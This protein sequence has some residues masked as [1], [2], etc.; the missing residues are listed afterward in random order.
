[1]YFHAFLHSKKNHHFL[2]FCFFSIFALSFSMGGSCKIDSA[3]QK[4]KNKQTGY[5]LAAKVN[6]TEQ[7]KQSNL[8][9]SSI[10]VESQAIPSTLTASDNNLS[11][12]FSYGFQKASKYGR[13]MNVLAYVTNNGK[14]FSGT[15]GIL[16]IP[17]SNSKE[18]LYENPCTIASGETKK[19]ELTATVAYSNWPSLLIKD[20]QE[21]IMLQKSFHVTMTTQTDIVFT[22]ILT[23]EPEMMDYI[24]SA[25]LAKVFFLDEQTLPSTIDGLDSLDILMISNFNTNRLSSDQITAILEW[26]KQGGMLVFGTGSTAAKTLSAFQET[27]F[28]GTIGDAKKRTTLLGMSH[29]EFLTI[30]EELYSSINQALDYDELTASEQEEKAEQ[31]ETAEVTVENQ[32]DT[33]DA[34]VNISIENSNRL[35]KKDIDALTLK[36]MPKDMISMDFENFTPVLSENDG[37]HLILK[38]NYGKG[39]ILAAA[40]ELGIAGRYRT[41]MGTQLYHIITDNFSETAQARLNDSEFEGNYTLSRALGVN[42]LSSYPH[43]QLYFFILLLYAILAGPILYFILKKLDSRHLLWILMPVSCFICTIIIYIAGSSTRITEPYIHYLNFTKMDSS[44]KEDTISQEVYFNIAAPYNKKYSV[45]LPNVSNVEIRGDNDYGMSY[46]YTDEPKE[47]S[48]YKTAIYKNNQDTT[49]I[50]N[51]YASFQAACFRCNHNQVKKDTYLPGTFDTDLKTNE[52]LTLTGTL[53]NQLGID[54][55][56]TAYLCNGKLYI[57]GAME[58]NT[59]V[60][61]EDCESFPF[62]SYDNLEFSNASGES[63][64][65]Q[66]AGGNGWYSDSDPLVRQ[67]YYAYQ[68]YLTSDSSLYSSSGRIIAITQAMPVDFLT[69]TGLS[70][71]GLSVLDISVSPASLGTMRVEPLDQ[72]FVSVIE[73]EQDYPNYRYLFNTQTMSY[74]IK[75]PENVL[76]LIYEEDSESTSNSSTFHG[77]ITGY[78]LLTGEYDILFTGGTA[79]KCENLSP[80]LTADGELTLRFHPDSTNG[81]SS[82]IIPILYLLRKI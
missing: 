53:T 5:A 69:D 75:N 68:Y 78:N 63:T 2:F 37:F 77:T 32:E 14:D 27:V 34:E 81:D 15:I 18:I 16:T 8:L 71:S 19:F 25:G 35:S 3:I 45:A 62:L 21:H 73:G 67:I 65:E 49:L 17:T 60:S 48:Y 51:D 72:S 59:T 29:Q 39:V 7:E 11:V 70:T 28:N 64:L 58:N 82:E 10:S 76:S 1:M 31:T 20:E 22:G 26:T 4:Q 42:N 47:S 46:S 74:Q 80:Y 41:S 56:Q 24:S 61:I 54:L 50:M 23:D 40:F 9:D 66:L 33:K 30:K 43:L 52:D 44:A 12:S 79:G 57:L 55:Y 36:K 6:T 13:K 38:N